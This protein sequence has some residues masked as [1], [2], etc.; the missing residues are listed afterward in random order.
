MSERREAPDPPPSR[1]FWGGLPIGRIFGVPIVVQPLWFLVVV[2]I[3]AGL[4]STIRDNVHGLSSNAAYAVALA[5]ALLLYAS[6]LLHELAHVF[7]ARSLGMQVRRVVLQFLG[8]ASEIVEE[9]PGEPAR[10]FMVAMAGPLCSVFLAGVGAAIA[11]AFEPTTVPRLFAEGFA[12]VNG[13]VAAF[14]LL[15]G[16]PLDGGRVLLSAVWQLT[17]DKT[18]AQFVSGWVGR[19]L[20]VALAVS[21]LYVQNIPTGDG[22]RGDQVRG[23]YLLL[24]AY[25]IW[26][27]ASWAIGRSK[28]S[29]VLPRLDI[30][31]MTRKALSVAA[32]LPV[33]EAVRRA[34]AAAA[35]ALVVVD[36]YGRPV[37]V[38]SEAAVMATPVQRQPWISVADLARPVGADLL[39]RSDMNGD[40]LLAAV[41]QH[42]ATEYLVVEPNGAL[43]GVLS[44]ADVV[45][46]LQAAG[47]R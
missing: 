44:R 34:H 5:F 26:A 21:A 46:A 14:N 41:Q 1:R 15:P 32:D 4:G 39:L 10:D 18:R 33:A 31:A 23:F 22:H 28:L 40:A 13:L 24:L 37:A 20:A 42:P 11:P 2:L 25:F 12:W 17:H 43:F 36:S 6:V 9:N 29:V 8:G 19:V 35:R 3:T 30:K 38:V 45:A 7:V 47:L 16:F 27:N